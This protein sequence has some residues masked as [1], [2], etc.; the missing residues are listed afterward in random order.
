MDKFIIYGGN[1]LRGTVT[2]SGSKNAAL[3]I[4]CSSILADGLCTFNNVPRLKDI[5]T[6]C[7]VLT[8]LGIKADRPA[9]NTVVLD[10]TDINSY[11]APY[12]LVKSMRAS[13]LVLGPLLAKYG[14]AKVSL[15][16]GCAIGVRPIDLHLKAFAKMGAEIELSHGYVIATTKKLKGTRIV[17]D[18]TTVGGTENVMMAACLA[19]G[20][21]IIEGAAREPEVVDLAEALNVMGAC[22]EGVGESTV[23]I[24]GVKS[25]SGLNY[26]IIPDRIELAT[27][28][29]AAAI[30]KGKLT[31]KGGRAGHVLAVIDKLM[32]MGIQIEERSGGN[33][34]VN[35]D[36]DLRPVDVETVPYPGF[37][38]DMQAQIMSLACI[39]D[40]AS[41][42]T[43]NIFENRFMHVPELMRMGAKLE[44]KGTTVIVRGIDR[45]QGASVMATDLRASASLVLAAL[46]AS[47]YT[48]IR[49]IYHLDRGYEGLDQKLIKLG[50]EV[51]REKGG[52]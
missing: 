12:D 37:P 20:T 22:I 34:Q 5:K 30:T 16:G 31:I 33:I 18:S 8:Q 48:E 6:I 52:L 14:K 39:A 26:D 17:F 11:E 38:T 32:E 49:R 29:V 46:N 25:L 13:I 1:A 3:P 4:L 42:I 43:E 50:A 40:G 51:S 28:L 9:Q 10:P 27:F 36:C 47:G 35:G 2:I 45:F 24:E 44:E 19:E 15:P 23:V 7:E 21:T 41:S